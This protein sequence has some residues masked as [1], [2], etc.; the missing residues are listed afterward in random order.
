MPH[1]SHGHDHD[2]DHD[3]A[4]AHPRKRF[5]ATVDHLATSDYATASRLLV[6]VDPELMHRHGLAPDEIVRCLL[7]TSP[8]PRD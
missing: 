7:Y 3:H 6:S 5:T 2:H 8:S 4:H 1:D